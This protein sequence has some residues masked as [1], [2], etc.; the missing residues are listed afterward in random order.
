MTHI[1]ISYSRKN[2]FIAKTFVERLQPK[3]A[4]WFDTLSIPGG[5]DWETEIQKGLKKSYLILIL[6]TSSSIASEWVKREIRLGK[7]RG[8]DILPIVVEKL[9]DLNQGLKQLE[10]DHIQF[11]DFTAIDL[12]LAYEQL[13]RRLD[14]MMADWA[15]FHPLMRDLN[16]PYPYCAAA[17]ETLGKLGESRAIPHLTDM[18][19]NH[20]D[21]TARGTAAVALGEI[22]D[23]R[24]LDDIIRALD[25]DYTTTPAIEALGKIGGKRAVERL[26][27]ALEED[28][29]DLEDR[30]IWA[31]DAL[32]ETRHVDAIEPLCSI[33]MQGIVHKSEHALKALAN[34]TDRRIAETILI[35]LND[36][37]SKL[38]L[39]ALELYVRL[40]RNDAQE[41]LLEL[42]KDPEAE[43]RRYAIYELG[44]LG[45]STVLTPLQNVLEQ[46]TEI[47]LENDEWQLYNIA[48]QAIAKLMKKH[49]ES[50][51][52]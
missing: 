39:Q 1:F 18:L 10:I 6:V 34:F 5:L 16:A 2:N 27:Q 30:D 41:K 37:K 13:F 7:E 45:S 23:E 51:P 33:L 47:D 28:D 12:D 52:E 26:I 44:E 9:D 14:D 35:V 19:F 31:I 43:I 11:I 15:K 46:L 50:P 25:E 20:R 3:Y 32:G 17:A 21:M 4:V 36:H 38:R 49:D 42:V 29:P 24:V 48:Q 22:G 8:L 40:Q